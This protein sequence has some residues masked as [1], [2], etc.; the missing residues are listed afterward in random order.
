MS[1][2]IPV[3]KEG[4]QEGSKVPQLKFQVVYER[5]ATSGL[6]VYENLCLIKS[7]ADAHY[8]VPC[9]ICKDSEGNEIEL[10]KGGY[11]RVLLGA[12]NE[13]QVPSS[14]FATVL[15]AVACFTRKGIICWQMR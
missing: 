3:K 15:L 12:R 2:Y 11:G 10:G 6:T 7:F 9:R 5:A 14:P 8:I 4:R 13:H 1:W